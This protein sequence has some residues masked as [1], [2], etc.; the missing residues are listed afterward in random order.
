MPVLVQPSRLGGNNKFP[1]PSRSPLR[2]FWRKQL[3][4]R[5]Y[6]LATQWRQ[7]FP[8]HGLGSL[9]L[10]R[11]GM[12]PFDVSGFEALVERLAVENKAKQRHRNT[13]PR[14]WDSMSVEALWDE[15]NDPRRRPTPR[16]TVEAI[17]ID[18][19]QRGIAALKDLV[20]IERLSR[21]DAAA[22]AQIDARISK[23]KQ[24]GQI[25]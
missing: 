22:K 21:C 9:R 11:A 10:H 12:P 5:R 25:Q 7:L 15:L 14:D 17:L 13:L 3:L 1:K 6:A 20:N 2:V 18:V 4:E 24:L 8:H 16:T 23:L 19:R